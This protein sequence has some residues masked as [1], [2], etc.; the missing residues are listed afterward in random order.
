MNKVAY[1]AHGGGPLP[2]LGDQGHVEMVAALK[3]L[4]KTIG[5]PDAIV[6][7]SA[8]WE[9][10][11]PTVTNAAAPSLLYDYYGFPAEA[12]EI[13]YP[14]LGAPQ[15]AND[16]FSVLTQAGLN[17][18]LDDDRDFD[19]GLFVPLKLMYPAA[20]IPCVQ[21]SLLKS[22]SSESH[23][24]MGE[25]LSHLDDRNLL[26]LGSGLSF[27]NLKGF[28]VNEQSVEENLQFEEWINHTVTSPDMGEV[29]RASRLIDWESAPGAR[30]CHPREEHLLPLH[31]C[32]GAAGR[33]ATEADQFE[34]MGRKVSNF[35]WQ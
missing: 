21:L 23:L 29:E 34:I 15:L 6:V 33:S 18:A 19:H 32:Y 22:L 35:L 25:A 14:A 24:K 28:G 16:I 2:L 13:Q 1:I 17:P 31:V 8:H 20:D 10:Q 9:L 30:F 12:Y 26:I 4:A 11:V 5:K 27:H 3:R 7:V